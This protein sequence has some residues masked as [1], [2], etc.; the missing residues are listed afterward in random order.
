MSK[1]RLDK[2]GRRRRLTFDNPE[3]RD[4]LGAA[5]RSEL[6]DAVATVAADAESCALV[7]TG[8]GSAFCAGADL[9]EVFG[10]PERQVSDSPSAVRGLPRLSSAADAAYSN[11]RG[12]TGSGGGRRSQRSPVLRPSRG[13]DN[14]PGSR[15]RLPRSACI[16]AVDA[17]TSSSVPLVGSGHSLYGWRAEQ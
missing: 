5:M 10:D 3:R 2:V 6:I 9:P 17:A 11:D 15:P 14:G 7:V 4:A 16:L 1:L 12:G 8:A 13:G